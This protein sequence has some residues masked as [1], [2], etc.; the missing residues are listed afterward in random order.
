M[1]N[2]QVAKNV[3][4]EKATSFMATGY[5]RTKILALTY[6]ATKI[7]TKVNIAMD[8]TAPTRAHAWHA[9]T[10]QQTHT[11]LEMET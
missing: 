7:A 10:S 1:M 4:P 6:N 5:M 3:R 11:T 2:L 8:A 9:A